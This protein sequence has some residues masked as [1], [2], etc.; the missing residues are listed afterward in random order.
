[1]CVFEFTDDASGSSKLVDGVGVA[2]VDDCVVVVDGDDCA[3]LDDEDGRHATA[4]SR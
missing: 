2:I 4:C 1:M 3:H